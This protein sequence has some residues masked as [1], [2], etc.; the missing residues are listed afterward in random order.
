MANSLSTQVHECGGLEEN[1]LPAAMLTT[2]HVTESIGLERH[3]TF[4]GERVKSK[5]PDVMACT[6]VLGSRIPEADQQVLHTGLDYSSPPSSAASS[7][8]S[9]A[10]ET[11]SEAADMAARVRLT[12]RTT[13]ESFSGT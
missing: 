12:P 13:A 3:F 11:S 2:R 5:K 8:P 10:S 6:D 1:K 4:R 7:A 9:A